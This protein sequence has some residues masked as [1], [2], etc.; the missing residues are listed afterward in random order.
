MTT[1]TANPLPTRNEDYGFFGTMR[2]AGESPET[3]WDIAS[4]LITEA[5]DARDGYGPEGVR[6]FLDSRSGRHFADMVSDIIDRR[7]LEMR[8][9]DGISLR[10]CI[11]EAIT[12]HQNWTTDRHTER[13]HGIPRGMPYL[14]GWVH[15]YAILAEAQPAS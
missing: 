1:T 7:A 14:T 3:A 5:T 6:D 4:R 8:A 9:S 12:R 15:H 2:L 10:D 13:D 11:A